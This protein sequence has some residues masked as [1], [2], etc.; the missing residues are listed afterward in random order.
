MSNFKLTFAT[1]NAIGLQIFEKVN[2]IFL[3]Y[4]KGKI[5]NMQS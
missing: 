5:K 3:E 2:L 4:F 1:I